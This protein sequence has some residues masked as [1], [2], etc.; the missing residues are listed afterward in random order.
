RPVRRPGPVGGAPRGGE[1][2]GRARRGGA[3]DARAPAR[4]RVRLPRPRRAFLAG[5]AR[6]PPEPAPPRRAHERAARVQT[7]R[8]VA[9][10]LRVAGPAGRG[11]RLGR[12]PARAAGP[13]PLALRAWPLEA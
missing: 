13:P 12:L 3:R 9:G 6:R 1:A 7:P 2:R 5:P 8:R 11:P 4:R 10:A